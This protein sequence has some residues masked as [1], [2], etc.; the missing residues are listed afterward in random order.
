MNSE[1]MTDDSRTKYRKSGWAADRRVND[2]EV[3]RQ[4]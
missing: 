4:K 2:L 1:A 3:G